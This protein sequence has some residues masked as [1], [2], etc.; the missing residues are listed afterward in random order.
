MGLAFDRWC[1][2][3]SRQS[4]RRHHSQLIFCFMR[5]ASRSWLVC[6]CFKYS[7]YSGSLTGSQLLR[8]AP[9]GFLLMPY[10]L[11]WLGI[12]GVVKCE[13][14]DAYDI[15]EIWVVG[16]CIENPLPG[17]DIPFL[18]PMLLWLLRTE[19]SSKLVNSFILFSRLIIFECWGQPRLWKSEQNI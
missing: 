11:T 19:Y 14:Y 10:R 17:R 15:C 16:F 1:S 13:S 12:T 4:R 5:W 7:A 3:G 8:Y 2:C 9:K 18:L 6:R